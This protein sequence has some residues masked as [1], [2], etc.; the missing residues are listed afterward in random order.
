MEFCNIEREKPPHSQ[1]VN[2]I[3]GI[4]SPNPKKFI[5]MYFLQKLIKINYIIPSKYSL[6]LHL[7]KGNRQLLPKEDFI[8]WTEEKKLK[9]HKRERSTF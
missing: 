4:F 1:E 2:I 7:L 9:V 8:A 5:I 3:L 6:K